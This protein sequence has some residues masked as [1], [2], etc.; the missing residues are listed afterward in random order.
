MS[1]NWQVMTNPRFFSASSGEA[2]RAAAEKLV[3][4]QLVAFPTETVYGLGADATNE[5][6][7]KR[8][9]AVKDRPTNHPLIVHLSSMDTLEIWAQE[10]PEYAI[11]LARTF[12]PGPMTLILK[13][14]HVAKDFIT[15]GQDSVGVR[16]PNNPIALE[17]L[18]RFEAIGGLGVAAPSANRFGR[19]SPTSSEDVYEEL[20]HVLKLGDLIIEGGRTQIGLESTIIDARNQSPRILR[21]GALTLEML[22]EYWDF[23][24]IEKNDE[25]RVSGSL[26][27]HYSP[28]ARILL[29]V[30]PTPGQGFIALSKVST[31]LGVIRLA[32]P[33]NAFDFAK[34]LYSSLREADRLG[35]AEVVILQPLGVGIEVAIRDRLRKASHE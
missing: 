21:P 30:N 20:G 18:S 12:W 35:L 16:I 29:D 32:A 24:V 3:S 19:V 28:N 34:F 8:I 27:K 7:V 22:N 14:T 1:H 6:A 13:R 23:E 25:L 31:P 10:I 11:Q 26:S 15:G 2:I 4:G 9:Y 5:S 17:L 33:K